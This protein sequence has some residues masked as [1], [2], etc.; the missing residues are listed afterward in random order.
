MYE[1]SGSVK[2][3]QKMIIAANYLEEYEET[4][5]WKFVYE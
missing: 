4:D 5:A 3:N 2:K 1:C